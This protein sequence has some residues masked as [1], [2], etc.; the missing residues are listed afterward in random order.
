MTSRKRLV[1]SYCCLALLLAVLFALSLFWGSVAL[2]PQAV[3]AALTGRGQDTLSVGIITQLRLPRAVMAA[4]LAECKAVQSGDIWCTTPSFFQ[5]S[6]A[7]AD[8]ML[9]LHAVFTG[10]TVSP[11]TL[12]FLTQIT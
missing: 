10:E 5:Q 4:L 3:L 8:F 2:T 11:D 9:D 12:H 6:M 1:F 7:L